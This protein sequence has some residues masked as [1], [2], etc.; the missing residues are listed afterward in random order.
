MSD[1]KTIHKGSSPPGTD[2]P[3]RVIFQYTDA[4]TAKFCGAVTHL[5]KTDKGQFISC[6]ST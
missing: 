6:D 3:A 1:G 5:S 2:N 4:N